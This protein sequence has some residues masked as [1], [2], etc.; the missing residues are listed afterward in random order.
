MFDKV[1]DSLGFLAYLTVRSVRCFV[2]KYSNVIFNLDAL[3]IIE[4]LRA[5]VPIITYGVGEK[6]GFVLKTEKYRNFSEIT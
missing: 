5:H 6:H 3:L 2:P 1:E 4:H